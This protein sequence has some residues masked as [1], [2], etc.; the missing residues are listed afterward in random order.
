MAFQEL[1]CNCSKQ[2][3][4]REK[5]FE[6]TN[7]IGQL[8]AKNYDRCLEILL[9]QPQLPYFQIITYS[10]WDEEGG[11]SYGMT[12]Y[13]RLGYILQEEPEMSELEGFRDVVL[14][15]IDAYW[16]DPVNRSIA[17]IRFTFTSD[18]G[19]NKTCWASVLRE[20]ISKKLLPLEDK[21]K[22]REPKSFILKEIWD[23]WKE[24]NTSESQE[25]CCICFDAECDAFFSP[26]A[27]NSF[28]FNCSRDLSTCPICRIQ[29]YAKLKMKT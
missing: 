16:S 27:H 2:D 21:V 17:K 26:C 14:Q 22:F 11:G 10:F 1:H 18:H 24:E 13:N 9:Q 12:V 23:T 15:V 19:T 4:N 25:E 29:G 7:F 6:A 8:R 28:C 20:E 5:A 3:C